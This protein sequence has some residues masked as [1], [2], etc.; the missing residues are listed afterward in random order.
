MLLTRSKDTSARAVKVPIFT[1]LRTDAL[2]SASFVISLFGQERPSWRLLAFRLDARNARVVDRYRFTGD[3][4]MRPPPAIIA[5]AV[6]GL[7]LAA[8]AQPYHYAINQP[9]SSLSYNI[10]F[11]APFQTS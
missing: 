6:C 9:N 1:G 3:S 7:P 10:S 5:A 8:L 2:S 11:S 4:P